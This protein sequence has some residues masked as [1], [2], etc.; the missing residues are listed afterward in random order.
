[1][2]DIAKHKRFENDRVVVWEF[3][4]DPGE[5]SGL[6]THARDYFF[7]IIDGSVQRVTDAEG[8]SLGEATL[9]PGATHWVTVEGDELVMDGQRL[10]ATHEATNIGT[11]TIRELLV[12]FKE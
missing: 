8:N 1:M 5:R 2:G 9:L 12:E 11:T 3:Q 7:H 4:L 10:P 6:H